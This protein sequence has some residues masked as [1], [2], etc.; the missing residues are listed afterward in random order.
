MKKKIL[1]ITP[2]PPPVTGQ[3]LACAELYNH[4]NNQKYDI[5]VINLSKQSFI[6]G[7]GSLRRVLE[8][9]KILFRIL[10]A[11]KNYDLIYFTPAESKMGSFKDQLIYLFLFPNLNKMYIHLHGGAGMRYLL[12]NNKK[13]IYKINKFFISRLA[14]V[15]VLGEALKNIYSGLIENN[16]IHAVENF[17]QDYLFIKNSEFKIK[18]SDKK[19]LKVLFLSNLL[20]GKGYLELL[21]SAKLLD[22]S[23]VEFHFAGGFENEYDK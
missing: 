15:I 7:K 20:P 9:A 3:S 21:E 6:S 14:G 17:S 23:Q 11:K 19:K 12:G 10:W 13:L 16:K 18:H 4:L 8:I 2:L 5:E 22:K 1:F